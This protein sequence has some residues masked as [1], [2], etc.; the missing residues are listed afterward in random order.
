M[1]SLRFNEMVTLFSAILI[2]NVFLKVSQSLCPPNFRRS[3]LE[4][5]T[6]PRAAGARVLPVLEAA[7]HAPVAAS[8]GFTGSSALSFSQCEK[9]TDDPSPLL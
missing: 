8:L 9:F 3:F 6:E 7:V 1:W 4:S 5:R 2:R